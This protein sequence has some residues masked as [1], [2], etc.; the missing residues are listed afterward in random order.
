VLATI[1]ASLY[2]RAGLSNEDTI[3]FLKRLLDQRL[4]HSDE[5]P[6][7]LRTQLGY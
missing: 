3:F 2:D 1:K 6:D 5:L 4:I 7:S